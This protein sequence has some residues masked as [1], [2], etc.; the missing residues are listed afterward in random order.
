MFCAIYRSA[1]RDQTYLYIEKKDDF[2]R[3]PQEL[4]KGFGKPVLAMVI[5]LASRE[6]LGSADINKVKQELQDKGY[7]LQVPPPPEDLLKM[8]LE[9][10]EK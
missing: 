10:K 8:H 9:N 5:S 1:L 6:K 2:S 4:L 7:Y 3:V